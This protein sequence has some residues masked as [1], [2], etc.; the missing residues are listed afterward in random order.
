[1]ACFTSL[2]TISLAPSNEWS[3][4]FEPLFCVDGFV[5]FQ[6]QHGKVRRVSQTIGVSETAMVVRNGFGFTVN[7]Y[8]YLGAVV[9]SK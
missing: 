5:D 2:K 3:Q 1:L 8:R 4:L 6:F 9:I 7:G